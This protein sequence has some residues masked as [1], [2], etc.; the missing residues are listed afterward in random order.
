MP[1]ISK[2]V[3]PANTEI[4]DLADTF[5]YT[6]TYDQKQGKQKIPRYFSIPNHILVIEESNSV[7]KN[8]PQQRLLVTS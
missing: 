3:Y 4:Q 2:P 1:K 8:I 7:E 5:Y 6:V